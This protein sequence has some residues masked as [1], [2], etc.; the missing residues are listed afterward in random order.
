[1]LDPVQLFALP[2]LLRSNHGLLSVDRLQ[3]HV[4]LARRDM[5]RRQVELITHG[6]ASTHLIACAYSASHVPRCGL[7]GRHVRTYSDHAAGAWPMGGNGGLSVHSS[8]R[9]NAAASTSS[10]SSRAYTAA[11]VGSTPRSAH[12]SSAYVRLAG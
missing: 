8:S 9:A 12:T 2:A 1:D 10:C 5:L 4:E 7:P 3:Q 6:N 11:L